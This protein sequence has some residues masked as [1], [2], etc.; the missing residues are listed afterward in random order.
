[1][2]ARTPCV[3]RVLSDRAVTRLGC[4]FLRRGPGTRV[5]ARH[6]RDRASACALTRAPVVGGLPR[7]VGREHSG[8]RCHEFQRKDRFQRVAGE[9]ASHRTLDSPTPKRWSMR[10]DARRSDAVDT[11]VDG[12]SGAEPAEQRGEPALPGASVSR[13]ELRSAGAARIAR[14]EERA[15]AEG[16]G[17]DPATLC[18]AGCGGFEVVGVGDL[19]LEDRPRSRSPMTK[20][21]MQLHASASRTTKR[22]IGGRLGRLVIASACPGSMPA[23]VN[24]RATESVVEHDFQTT[25]PRS[26][27]FGRVQSGVASR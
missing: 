5:A 9:L 8:R 20:Q 14:A 23:A 18:S 27:P 19:A 16:R 26:V 12:G 10:R 11:T 15:F 22:A 24:E 17:P 13:G 25:T 2:S 7:Q 4:D 1:M 6:P 21:A 3:R